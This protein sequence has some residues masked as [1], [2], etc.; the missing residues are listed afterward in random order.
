[1]MWGNSI[2]QNETPLSG[3]KSFFVF[4]FFFFGGGGGGGG[5]NTPMQYTEI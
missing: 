5:L 1:M 3:L 2:A 4:F